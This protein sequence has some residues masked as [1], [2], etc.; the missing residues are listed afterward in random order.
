MVVDSTLTPPPTPN[1]G[2]P[3]RFE[4]DEPA[5]ASSST[6]PE[7]QLEND[8]YMNPNVIEPG[9]FRVPMLIDKEVRE[10]VQQ[11]IVQLEREVNQLRLISDTV[12]KLHNQD[13]IDGMTGAKGRVNWTDKTKAET[14]ETRYILG[15]AGFDHLRSRYP[16]TYPCKSTLNNELRNNVKVNYGIIEDSFKLAEIK[17]RSLAANQKYAALVMDEIAIKECIEYDQANKCMLGT[18]TVPKSEDATIDD[19]E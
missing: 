2:R 12:K 8:P 18:I 19:G 10:L 14:M 7:Q 17:A 13:Q 3:I 11:R 6:Q 15:E 5:V 1:L 4:F 9:K 16:G